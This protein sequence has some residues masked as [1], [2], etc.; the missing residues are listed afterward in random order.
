MYYFNVPKLTQ[1]EENGAKWCL[2][3]LPRWSLGP[4]P[5]EPALSQAG[6][7]PLFLHLV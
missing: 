3:T 2:F 4:K 1:K 6:E 7:L 5:N